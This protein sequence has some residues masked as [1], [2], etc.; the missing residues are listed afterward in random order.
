VKRRISSI[1]AP[2][3]IASLDATLPPID[4]RRTV[5]RLGLGLGLRRCEMQGL[6]VGD[7]RLW[8][9]RP[10][11]IVRPGIAKGNSHGEVPAWY[12]GDSLRDLRRWV[13]WRTLNGANPGDPLILSNRGQRVS[14]RTLNRLWSELR[15]ML[16]RPRVRLHDLRHTSVS[17]VADR[18]GAIAARDFARHSSLAITDI[19][20]HPIDDDATVG[21]L[22]D[23]R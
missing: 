8:D 11:C 23:G 20:A 9:H 13:E 3:E 4:R 16:N 22:Y 15:D 10:I 14:L 21:N 18:R 12:D 6:N 5:L 7:L 2:A 1:L 19:Y 17:Y